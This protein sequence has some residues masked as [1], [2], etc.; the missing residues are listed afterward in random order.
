MN[1]GAAFRSRYGMGAGGGARTRG[2]SGFSRG[3]L[4]A[5]PR[6]KGQRMAS[7]ITARRHRCFPRWRPR[8]VNAD[9]PPHREG[10]EAQGIEYG[11]PLDGGVRQ[12][13]GDQNAL[14]HLG[15]AFQFP[16]LVT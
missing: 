14:A 2:T 15:V 16:H 11:V 1:Q 12:H 10:R 3:I 6:I 4:R 7:W 8:R 13:D 5:P 9:G